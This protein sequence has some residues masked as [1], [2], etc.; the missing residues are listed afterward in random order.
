ML[1]LLRRASARLWVPLAVLVT[2]VG[3]QDTTAPLG[4]KS[5]AGPQF[6]TVGDPT[7]SGDDSSDVDVEETIVTSILRQAPG[8]PVL[9]TYQVS[10]W[11]R[12]KKAT[13]VTVNYQPGPG[14]AVGQPFLWFSVPKDGLKK[15]AAGADLAGKDS[16]YITLTIDPVNFLVDF[17]PHGVLFN[18]KHP[19]VLIFWYQNA[20]QDLNGDGVVDDADR[21]LDEQLTI[22]YRPNTHANWHNKK[23]TK[24]WTYPYIFTPIRHFSQ[25]AVAW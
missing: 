21:E 19:A 20:N 17:Q 2:F 11:V 18:K 14:E 25:Y 22:V 13:M 8:A 7:S 24:G 10:F 1:T 4:D 23:S 5:L 6:A 15:G 3:C 12:K 16:V 9:E